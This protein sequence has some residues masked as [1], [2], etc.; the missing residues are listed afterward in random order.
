MNTQY[1]SS[2]IFSITLVATLGGLLFGYDTAVISGTVESL[3]TVFVAPQNLSESAANSLLGFCVASALI[4]CIIGGALGGYCSSRFG[5]RDSLK[6][7]AVLFFIS[8]VG[9]A[10]P[11]L[12][13]TSI[14][15]DNTVPVYL[16]GYVPEFVIYR[17]IGGIGVGLASMLSPMYIAE[18]APAHIRGK[19]VSFNQFAIIFGQL[20]VYCVNYFIA[21]SGDASW[22]NTDGWRYMFASECI[23]ALLFLMLLYTVPESPR[24]LMSRGKQEQAEGI[25]RKIMGNTLATQAVQEIK[26]SLDHGRKTGGRLLMFG[27]GVIVIGVMLSIFQQFVG[28][29]VVLYYA[30]RIFEN[31]GASGD[32]SMIQTV[33]MGVVNIIFTL[34]AIFTVDKFGRKPLLIIGSLG[35]A[36]G[37]F[38]VAFCDQMGIKGIVPVLSII[39]Y[40]A[41]FMM[42]WGP[43]CWVLIAEIFPNTIRGQAVAI[44]VAFQWVFNYLVS[45]TFPALYDFSPMFAYSLYGIICLLAALF[46]WRSVP[47]TKGRTLEDMTELWRSRLAKK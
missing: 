34:V 27:V 39:V 10:W 11:E 25:L 40:A 1:N 32:S 13:F 21:R 31:L 19:L 46:V 44:A 8:G 9:S 7:A 18:L 28:I 22:L 37:A 4:G 5:R 6:I 26:H 45:S 2:Y 30:P 24:W 41:F 12:G 3:N 17:I 23:P 33:V 38:A 15:P 14:N 29:N 36:V 16:A 42:S 20:L 43:I 47:E 35:M